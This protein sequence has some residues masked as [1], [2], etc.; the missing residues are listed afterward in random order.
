MVNKAAFWGGDR[1]PQKCEMCK[2]VTSKQGATTENIGRAEEGLLCGG[3]LKLECEEQKQRDSQ[4]KDTKE[5][6]EVDLIQEP[7]VRL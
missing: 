1:R 3:L 7:M 4:L 6:K 5:G 2:I